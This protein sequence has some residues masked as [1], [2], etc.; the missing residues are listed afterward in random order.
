MKVDSDQLLVRAGEGDRDAMGELYRRHKLQALA[1]F[2]RLAAGN[3]QCE[4]M[5]QE[6]F[7]R[8]WKNAPRYRSSGRY[9]SFMFTIAANVLRDHHRRSNT[10]ERTLETEKREQRNCPRNDGPAEAGMRAE[11][12][13][14]LETA[15]GQLPAKERMVV[16]LSEM[17]GLPYRE[18][19]E[20]MKCRIGTVG[21]RKAR[22]FNML[23][24]LLD[25]HAP[26]TRQGGDVK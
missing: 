5:T 26:R 2:R 12:S 18:I 9:M 20:V 4:D 19:A 23:R 1:F 14:S 25:G 8:M 7:L 10:R 3:S 13:E 21:S 16:V 24:G 17:E 15:L 22:A 11:F 6:V